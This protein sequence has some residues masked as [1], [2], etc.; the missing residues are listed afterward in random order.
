MLLLLMLSPD[1][2]V[3]V[4]AQTSDLN[5]GP[6]VDE[7]IFKV[8]PNKDDRVDAIL[9]G[10]VEMDFSHH[11]IADY[12]WLDVDDPD[13]D[14]YKALRNGYGHITINCRDYPLNISGLR[15]A[16]AYAFDK[17]TVRGEI[18]G[19]F[20]ELHDSLVPITSGYCIEDELDWHYY[21]AQPEI[22]NQ[23]LDELGFDINATT[24][25]RHAPNGEPFDIQIE[26]SS[27]F[28]EIAGGTAQ[29]GVN[30]LQALHINASTLGVDFNELL[31]RLDG[32]GDYD[33]V[34]FGFDFSNYDV[35]WLADE[36][37]S[38]YA[39]APYRNPTNFRNASYDGWRDQLLYGTT[40]DEVYEAAAEMQKILHNNVPRL[41]VYL[42]YHFKIYRVDQF[43]GYVAGCDG[44]ITN[45]WTS[46]KIHRLDGST[47]GTVT[48]AIGGDPDSFNIFTS[49]A[50]Y[51]TALFPEL[52]PSL[53]SYSPDMT[54]YPYLAE[55]LITEIHADNPEV[56]DGHT[57][58]TIDI[59]RNA[60]WADGFPLTAEDIVY[61]Q[62]YDGTT[63]TPIGP[64]V[65]GLVAAYTLSPDRA[66]LE[67]DTE[68]YWHFPKFA[69]DY[70]IPKHIFNDS[71]G[72]DWWDWNPVLNQAHPHVTSG[73]YILTEYEPGAF[74]KISANPDFAYY[75]QEP[76]TT[77]Y[78]ATFPTT[79]TTTGTNTPTR[80]NHLSLVSLAV[81]GVSSVVI[82]VAVIEIIRNKQ[83][84]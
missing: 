80:N 77:D 58:F 35:D 60:T 55:N 43:T 74:Y 34:F 21:D 79:S 8:I 17:E 70:I 57:R 38:E 19:G 25:Y 49:T 68:S 83:T 78:I 69:Y 64:M 36:Y 7:I 14:L 30:A 51:S 10:E 28:P 2:S 66:I 75:P 27:S 1:Q 53:Y 24:G 5:I 23:I 12:G 59:I 71:I 42:N 48:I 44:Q 46:R 3:A 61:T 45:P 6:Y 11:D 20:S 47:G 67:Y 72:D 16:F 22:G 41:V 4:P 31:P 26:Y 33:M 63:W 9:S 39:N 73:P 62:T 54:P 52:W 15:R 65:E 13:I 29:I 81:G 56:P 40:Y 37:W 84:E 18:W 32:H 50:S 76:H 82:V